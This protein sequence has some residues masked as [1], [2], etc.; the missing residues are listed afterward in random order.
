MLPDIKLLYRAIVMQ[1][2]WHWQKSRCTDEW[3]II[4][5]PE[6][7]LRPLARLISDKGGKNT[8]AAYGILI[9]PMVDQT[10]L[11]IPR[12]R[13]PFSGIY[14]KF[15]APDPR[16]GSIGDQLHMCNS[17]SSRSSSNLDFIEEKVL[18][19]QEK[20]SISHLNDKSKT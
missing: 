17:E 16:S 10:F 20:F 13:V 15:D 2:A 9:D 5:S 1:T 3:D 14:G 18:N 7:N 12:A 11:I 6:T 19:F 4:E 8:Q